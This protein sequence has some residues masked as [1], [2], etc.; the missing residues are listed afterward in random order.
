M[1]KSYIFFGLLFVG[2]FLLYKFYTVVFVRIESCIKFILF[3]V[4]VLAVISPFI[5]NNLDLISSKSDIIN[6][7]KEKYMN[8]K[9]FKRIK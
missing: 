1:I 9:K 7:L 2:I 3:G 8:K 5:I 6:I 4:G